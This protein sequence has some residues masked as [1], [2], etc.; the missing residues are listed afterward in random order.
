MYLY[1]GGGGSG[2][3]IDGYPFDT[4]NVFQLMLW[5]LVNLAPI[6]QLLVEFIFTPFKDNFGNVT[7][8]AQIIL[9]PVTIGLIWGAQALKAIFL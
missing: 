2:V 4:T 1:T 5:V 3:R 9:S 8:L 7:T 6:G